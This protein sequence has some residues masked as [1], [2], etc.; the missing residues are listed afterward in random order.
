MK[1]EPQVFFFTPNEGSTVVSTGLQAFFAVRLHV[2][3]LHYNFS[4]LNVAR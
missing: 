3:N 2:Y 1:P 4:V